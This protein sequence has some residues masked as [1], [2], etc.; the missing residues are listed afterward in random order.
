M[1]TANIVWTTST[2]IVES[3][4]RATLAVRAGGALASLC[5]VAAVPDLPPRPLLTPLQRRV[6]LRLASGLS[7]RE[8]ALEL[9]YSYAYMREVAAAAARNLG[10]DTAIAAVYVGAKLG[11]I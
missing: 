10:A 5:R 6:L 2:A 1:Y 11:L 4:M 7:L 9:S 8:T 3:P